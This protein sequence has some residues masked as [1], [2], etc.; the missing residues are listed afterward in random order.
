MA[1][2][3][4]LNRF[5]ARYVKNVTALWTSEEIATTYVIAKDIAEAIQF[6]SNL[7]GFVELRAIEFDCVSNY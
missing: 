7:P 1:N 4:Y 2:T 6:V 3:V 5:K